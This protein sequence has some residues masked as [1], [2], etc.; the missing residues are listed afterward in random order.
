MPAPYK[1]KPLDSVKGNRLRE[2]RTRHSITLREL[3]KVSGYCDSYL[4]YLE[5]GKR[6]WSDEI[7][8]NYLDAIY[9]IL[10]NRAKKVFAQADA[11]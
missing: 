11:A 6:G 10:R 1:P 2:N 5:N 4:C 9:R 3:S 8:Q 7:E